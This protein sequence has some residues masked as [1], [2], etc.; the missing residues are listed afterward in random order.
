ME[1]QASVPG[2][3]YDNVGGTVSFNPKT[4]NQR[5]GLAL[6]NGNVY[7]AWASYGDRDPYHGWV[8]AYS[9]GTL[10]Q[11]GVLCLTP[12]GS[13][14]GIWQSGQPLSSDANGDLYVATGNGSFDAVRNFGE[15]VI[16]LNPNLSSVLDWFAPDN[17]AQLNG[18]DL[19]LGSAGLLL[20]PGT[21][22]VI[23]AGKGGRFYVMSRS[24]LGHTQ[25]GNG[26]IV[27]TFQVTTGGHLHGAPAFWN[28]PNGPWVMFGQEDY[29][30]AY[31]FNGSLFN[32]TPTSKSTFRAPT[33]MPGGFL[34]ISANGAQPG[35][36]ILWA[37]LP[38]AED[39]NEDVVSGVLR[40]FDTTDLTHE[41]WDTR[42]V[43]ARDDLGDYGKFVPPTVANGRV[44]VSTFSNRLL[45][46]GLLGSLPA[47]TGGAL[48]GSGA[49][50]TAPLI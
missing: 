34:T 41:L 5:A 10:Q 17:W 14:A 29:L 40:A 22:D 35:T 27:Q 26:Q 12:D 4:Q 2:S 43:P 44:Y 46:Y 36:G 50:S 19:D 23:A 25:T 18:G 48:S 20:M 7:I 28:G 13:K 30:K 42:M 45:V 1:I 32:T 21:N 3:G 6:A 9:A 33:G 24:N 15:S 39:A 38:Y 37:A 31:A 16:K 8:M 49:V 47:V 11:V